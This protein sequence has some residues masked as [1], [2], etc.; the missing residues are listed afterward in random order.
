MRAAVR[1][2]APGDFDAWIT[3]SQGQI[4]EDP[5]ERGELW[6]TQY[7]CVACHSVDGT[8]IV[9]PSWKGVCGSE[10]TLEDGTTVTV[11][12]EYLFES[13]RN[14]GAKIVEGFPDVMLPSYSEEMTDEQIEDVITYICSLN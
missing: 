5:V 4:P 14:P 13:I 7:G 1:V 11:D 8:V 2:V 10:E 9:G 6:A 3:E 12:E